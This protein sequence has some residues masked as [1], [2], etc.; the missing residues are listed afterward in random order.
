MPH[1]SGHATG[2]KDTKA[3]QDYAKEYFARRMPRTVPK[4]KAVNEGYRKARQG[5]QKTAQDY[6]RERIMSVVRRNPKAALEGLNRY[7]VKNE[8][9]ARGPK[10]KGGR[11]K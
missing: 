3:K 1:R 2:R 4:S 10:R 9:A 7:T 6:A 8:R 5:L 11:R